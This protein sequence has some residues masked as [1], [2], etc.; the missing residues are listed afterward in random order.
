MNWKAE[1]IRPHE[2]IR[3]AVDK[4]WEKS[5]K[6]LQKWIKSELVPA[7]IYGGLQIPEPVVDT[8]MYRWISSP[9][10]LSQLG[11]EADQ[12]PRLLRAYEKTFKVSYTKNI[13]LFQFGDVARLKLA[14][15]H[16]ASGTG[17][18]KIE[19]W[20]EWIIDGT[21][22][23]SGFVPRSKLPLRTYSRKKGEFRKS[24]L[25]KRIRVKSSPGGLMLPQGVFGST[26]SWQAPPG[27][28]NYDADGGRWISANIA[29]IENLIIVEMTGFLSNHL[30]TS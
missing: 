12:P 1:L 6:D 27:V 20:M 15:P 5:L 14:T 22:V 24:S 10:G 30:T 25:L 11:I 28:L 7:L 26:G 4:A 3:I 19:S 21:K 2:T 16:R 13:L 8:E 9:D 18:L 23:N 17:N 29:W